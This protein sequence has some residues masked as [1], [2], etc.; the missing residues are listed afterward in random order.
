VAAAGRDRWKF[1]KARGY[2]MTHTVM[3][4]A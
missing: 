4:R 3:Q 2:E 1:Y